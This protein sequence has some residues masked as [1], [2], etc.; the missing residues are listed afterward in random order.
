MIGGTG[1][2][3]KNFYNDHVSRLGYDAEAKK[4]QDLYLDG[5]H[6]EVIAAVTDELIDDI[7][8]IGTP[9]RIIDRAQAWRDTPA[10]M[11]SL[12]TSQPEALEVMAKAFL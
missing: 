8:L 12:S 10:T 11:L 5:K 3:G 7:T 4:I 9:A 2:R 6:K 1:A